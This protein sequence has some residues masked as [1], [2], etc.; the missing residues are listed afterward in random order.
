MLLYFIPLFPIRKLNAFEDNLQGYMVT[1]M[2][3]CHLL[4]IVNFTEVSSS[5]MPKPILFPDCINNNKLGLKSPV[6][7]AFDCQKIYFSDICGVQC[8]GKLFSTCRHYI[9]STTT[10]K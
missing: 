4:I 1:N 2:N 9:V 8:R 5:T 7:P 10:W 3:T 6:H